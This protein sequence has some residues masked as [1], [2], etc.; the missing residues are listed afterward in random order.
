MIPGSRF[1]MNG[2]FA[3]IKFATIKIESLCWIESCHDRNTRPNQKIY[4]TTIATTDR[5]ANGDVGKIARRLLF[6]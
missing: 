3:T 4:L 5:I 6:G 1:A 2:L